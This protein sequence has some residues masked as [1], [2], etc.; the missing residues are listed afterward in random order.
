MKRFNRLNDRYFKF[1]F[2]NP[3]YKFLLVEFLNEVLADIPAGAERLPPVVDLAYSDR[4][5]IPDHE[6]DK[7]P[8]FDVVAQCED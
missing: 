5:T 1:L 6:A 7:L 4:E 8:R 3:K 2:A